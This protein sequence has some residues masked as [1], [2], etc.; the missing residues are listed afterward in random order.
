MARNNLR[1]VTDNKVTQVNGSSTAKSLNDYKSQTDSG[2]SFTITTSSVT[3]PVVIVAMLAEQMG[4]VT[5]T[6]TGQGSV[7]EATISNFTG[8]T[9]GYGGVKYVA[10]YFTLNS[11]TTSFTVTFSQS[12]KVSKFIVGN[13]WSPKYNT[14]YGVQVGYEDAATYERL[15]NGDLYTTVAPRNKT[16]QFELQYM[17]ESDKFQLF[18]IYR[19]VGKAKALFASIFPEDDDQ[20]KEQMYSMY[21]KFATIGNINYVMYTMY[22]SS[23]QLTE[24]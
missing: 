19:S 17:D 8:Q 21:G 15:Q 1:I 16:M 6:V 12:V 7:T 2:T 11:G 14:G 22:A 5:M 20:Q 4:S 13:Y 9:S 10:K 18:D 24:V 3:G 23:I